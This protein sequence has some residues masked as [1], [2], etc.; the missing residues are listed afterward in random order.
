MDE[1]AEPTPEAIKKAKRVYWTAYFTSL[2]FLTLLWGVGLF[3]GKVGILLPY[4]G[5]F[6]AILHGINPIS[7][8]MI[9]GQ[10]TGRGVCRWAGVSLERRSLETLFFSP[11]NQIRPKESSPV[12]LEQDKTLSIFGMVLAIFLIVTIT[13]LSPHASHPSLLKSCEI[14]IAGLGIWSAYAWWQSRKN[15]VRIDSEGICLLQGSPWNLIPPRLERLQWSEIEQIVLMRTRTAVGD[16]GRCQLFFA[17]NGD[18][19][20]LK[21]DLPPWGKEN[22]QP[23]LARIRSEKTSLSATPVEERPIENLPDIVRT[24]TTPINEPEVLRIRNR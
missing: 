18:N 24:R 2:L 19:R 3:S 20:W 16:V 21:V 23:I 12:T 7:G 14:L 8:F 22:L 13:L 9:L 5:S 10:Y 6:G 4:L 15:L 11:S 1:I 17:K